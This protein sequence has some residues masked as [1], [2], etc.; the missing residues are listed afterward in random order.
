MR[1]LCILALSQQKRLQA[2]SDERVANNA[3][4]TLNIFGS[5]ATVGTRAVRLAGINYQSSFG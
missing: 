2:Q 3:V 1:C 4:M 5:G